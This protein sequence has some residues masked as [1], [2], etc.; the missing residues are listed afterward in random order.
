MSEHE[1][2]MIE[3][4]SNETTTIIPS[5]VANLIKHFTLVNYDSRDGSYLLLLSL[6]YARRGIIRLATAILYEGKIVYLL[7]S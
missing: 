1:E 6:I 7:L 5:S 4:S 3:L 2:S